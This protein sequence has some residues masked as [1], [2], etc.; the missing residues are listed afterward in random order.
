MTR[1][2]SIRLLAVVALLL[3]SQLS[4]TVAQPPEGEER[5]QRRQRGDRGG[6]RGAFGGAGGRSG[7][8]IDRAALLR[9]DAVRRELGIDELQG[10]T[11]QAAL[12]AYQEERREARPDFSGFR[13]LSDE[14][15]QQLL[16]E[17][18]KSTE[19]LSR[20]ADETL[21]V[22]LEPDQLTRLD[23][24]IM[25]SRVQM[26]PAGTLQDE[27]LIEQLGLTEEQADRLKE[28]QTSA[29]E[30]LQERQRQVFE[31]FRSGGGGGAGIDFSQLRE[32]MEAMQKEI[33]EQAMAVLTEGQSQKLT[34]MKGEEFDLQ[35]VLRNMR[36]RFG[37]GGFGRGGFP[38]GRGSGPEG[39]G[40][41][42]GAPRRNQRPPTDD[43]A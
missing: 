1:L 19:E 37:R 21:S 3:W 38:G 29:T 24:I 31:Q 10:G 28:L 41:R 36:G 15:R 13:D 12:E 5:P 35:T 27:K 33:R 11:I 8:R 32:E 4:E 23:Q 40:G 43:E 16:E 39:R 6:F 34:E 14:E 18:R 20:T 2:L 17:M 7:F 26:D 9:S 22:L 25:Q 42:R 30:R